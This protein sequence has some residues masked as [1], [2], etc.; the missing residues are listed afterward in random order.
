[1]PSALDEAPIHLESKREG[2]VLE[3]GSGEGSHVGASDHGD[4]RVGLPGVGPVEPP[5]TE[6]KVPTPSHRS[7]PLGHGRLQV[8]AQ[9]TRIRTH[10]K[11][12][13]GQGRFAGGTTTQFLDPARTVPVHLI[14]VLGIRSVVEGLRRLEAFEF[15]SVSPI[16]DQ[17]ELDLVAARS[18]QGFGKHCRETA[19]A[20]RATLRANRIRHD[21]VERHDDGAVGRGIVIHE[22]GFDQRWQHRRL[23]VDIVPLVGGIE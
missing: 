2:V 17:E 11:R 8:S 7:G 15:Q 23:Y 21:A 9:L 22:G 10:G 5:A 3:R 13:G 12:L 6:L 20:G 1:M 14:E 18:E 19:P 16:R 4:H